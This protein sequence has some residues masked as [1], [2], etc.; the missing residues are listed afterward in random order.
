MLDGP[1]VG[2][3][4]LI[5]RDDEVLLIRR[6]GV[7]GSGT[8]STPGGHLDAGESLDA[9]ARRE[10]MEEV[11]I[12]LGGV[13]FRALTDDLFESED[14]H[15]ITV[16]M[17]GEYLGADPKLNA[18]YEMSEVRWFKLDELPTELFLPLA[19]LLA[20]RCHPPE[21]GGLASLRRSP[22]R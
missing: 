13:R 11:G 1:R 17:D 6:R 8:W 20:G 16:W 9:C 19:N 21:Q 18:S 4:V 5:R 3:G 14:L 2:V 7:H 22:E 10:A 12:E 15:Y